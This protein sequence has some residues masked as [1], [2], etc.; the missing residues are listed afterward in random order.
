MSVVVDGAREDVPGVL[1]RSYLD[2]ASLR[3]SHEDYGPRP[4]L[5]IRSIVLHTTQGVWPQVV[6]PGAGKAG[7]AAA[8]LHAWAYDRRCAG[9]HLLIDGD[10]AVFCAADLSAEQT[11]HATSINPYSIGLE[12]VQ[13][14]D[15]SLYRAQLD[16]VVALVDW[17]TRRLRIQRQVPDVYRGPVPR[18]VEGGRDFVG[19][20]GHR[21]QSSNRGRGDPGDCV[22]DALI[23]AGYEPLNL[24][25]GDDRAVWRERQ[26]KLGFRE[27]DVDGVP[28]DRTCDALATSRPHGLWVERP[29]DRS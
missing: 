26:R 15:G 9:S 8:N 10:G 21:D 22:F 16:A 13:R 4:K 2:D 29:G 25:A 12:I 28:L 18:L 1:S 3:L 14:S 6:W 20:C 5:R 19:V 11:W 24:I 23:A 17:L 27:P 7:G